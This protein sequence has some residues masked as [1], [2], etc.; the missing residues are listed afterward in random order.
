MGFYCEIYSNIFQRYRNQCITNQISTKRRNCVAY[1]YSDFRDVQKQ[2]AKSMVQSLVYQICKRKPAIP[3]A[4]IRM[5]DQYRHNTKAQEPGLKDDLLPAL[6]ESLIGFK[7]IYLV[8]D[9]LDECSSTNNDLRTLLTTIRTIYMWSSP[10]LHM[11]LASRFV[12]EIHEKIR[13]LLAAEGNI[14]IDLH[15]AEEVNNDIRN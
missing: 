5:W 3:K 6:Q 11:M 14:E 10:Q 13:P 12:S 2:K 4:V 9:G 1:F 15:G 8:L 7:G